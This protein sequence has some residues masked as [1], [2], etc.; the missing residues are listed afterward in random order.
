MS[1]GDIIGGLLVPI[2]KVDDNNNIKVDIAVDK[3]RSVNIDNKKSKTVD[4]KAPVENLPPVFESDVTPDCHD[5]ELTQEERDSILV[6]VGE[7]YPGRKHSQ[8]RADVLNAAGVPIKGEFVPGQWTPKGNGI[9]FN[10][11]KSLSFKSVV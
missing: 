10:Y 6:M 7:K 11:S 5:M 4:K 1:F 2:V 8:Y 9:R 3:K